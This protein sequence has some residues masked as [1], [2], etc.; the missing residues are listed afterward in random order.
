MSDN[1]K[2]VVKYF[3]ENPNASMI[4]ISEATGISKSSVQR[5]LNKPAIANMVIPSL[6]CMIKEKLQQNLIKGRQKGG[7]NTFSLYDSIKDEQGHFVGLQATK[8]DSKEELKKEDIKM[9]VNFFSHYPYYTLEQMA[10]ELDNKYTSDYIYKCLTDS[11]VEEIFGGVIASAINKQLSDNKYSI[12][13][14]YG[15]YFDETH[16][17]QANLTPEEIHILKMRFDGENIKSS[18][19]VAFMLGISKTMVNK[20]ED[21]ALEKIK[22]YQEGQK[23][24]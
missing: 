10:K 7:R 20:I 14:K 11:R 4:Q 24:Y 15:D 23:R 22:Q 19:A 18:E 3:L 16:F 13:K 6:G 21:R 5:Y 9:I 2:R 17:E 1:E 12:L 8:T